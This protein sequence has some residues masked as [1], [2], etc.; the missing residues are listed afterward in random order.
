MSLDSAVF[1]SL[2]GSAT[3]PHWLTLIGLFATQHLMQWIAGGTVAIF[4]TGN[5]QV[6]L[7]VV[8]LLVAITAAWL[9]A[10]LGQHF[11]PIDRPFTVGL[12]KQ[13]LPHAASH[14]FPS[15]HATVAFAFATAVALTAGRLHWALLALAAA[16]LVA[17]SR[18]YLGLHFPSDVLAGALGGSVCGWLVCRCPFWHSPTTHSDAAK[19]M[20]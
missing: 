6:K 5:R 14:G 20:T 11:I 2:N 7:H 13:W 9:L 15:T 18:V 1:L 8:Q 17:W 16:G 3:S 10:R 19:E 12:G 4:V